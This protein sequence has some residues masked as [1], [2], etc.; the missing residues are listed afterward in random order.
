[1]HRISTTQNRH[2]LTDITHE[3]EHSHAEER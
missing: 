1:L 3:K 2:H